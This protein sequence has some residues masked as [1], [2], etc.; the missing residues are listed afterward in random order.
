[1]QGVSPLCLIN[2]TYFRTTVDLHYENIHGIP[3]VLS[4]YSDSSNTSGRLWKFR[5]TRTTSIS[6]ENLK[7]PCV[8]SILYYQN[9]RRFEDAF[10]R[11]KIDSSILSK[12]VYSKTRNSNNI[13]EKF[14]KRS[15]CLI[16]YSG[17]MNIY[18][19][20]NKT[21]FQQARK[22]GLVYINHQNKSNLELHC[23]TADQVIQVH[24]LPTA[25]ASRIVPLIDLCFTQASGFRIRQVGLNLNPKEHWMKLP[26]QWLI[27]FTD[28]MKFLN[29]SLIYS[30]NIIFPT[31]SFGK[32][33]SAWKLETYVMISSYELKIL[34]CYVEKYVN[35][36][37]YISAFD[38]TTWI[39]ILL[40]GLLMSGLLY[41]HIRQ[42]IPSASSFSPLLFFFSTFM[43][44]SYNIPLALS[45]DKVYRIVVSFWLLLSVIFTNTYVSNVISEIEVPFSGERINFTSYFWAKSSRFFPKTVEEFHKIIPFYREYQFNISEYMQ[46]RRMLELYQY[47]KEPKNPIN[48]TFLEDD[49]LY[50]GFA[51]LSNPLELTHANL[52][53]KYLQLPVRYSVVLQF[54]TEIY[55]CNQNKFLHLPYCSYRVGVLMP[56]NRHYPLR[57]SLSI[58]ID[59]F[60]AKT[61]IENE[62]IQCGKSAY[63]ERKGEGEFKYLSANYPQKSF[64]YLKDSIDGLWVGFNL[65]RMT[66][67]E[68]YKVMVRLLESGYLMRM[69]FLQTDR[70]LPRRINATNLIKKHDRTFVMN[71]ESQINTVFILAFAMLLV[72]T[73]AFV[74]ENQLVARISDHWIK[75]KHSIECCGRI[76]LDNLYSFDTRLNS[77]KEFSCVLL[78]KIKAQIAKV[79]V[80]M[81]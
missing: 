79:R 49:N 50:D 72:A 31:V 16:L 75:V 38:K 42:N 61:A 68:T 13:L 11:N 59:N 39:M 69:I 58:P 51:L 12:W 34:T 25:N 56:V 8:L 81:H 6:I 41:L 30:N 44:E 80:N 2:I 57:P 22:V 52:E 27:F 14:Q 23:K 21:Y 66:N 4:S 24:I 77:D 20:Q 35:Y 17:S 26:K 3:V 28:I 64:Y 40:S 74:S 33:E 10:S 5:K 70:D 62:L 67:S 45:T 46:S 76:F 60:Y 37:M 1:L 36:Y 47:R 18:E 32:M 78:L 29:V 63:M 65:E 19:L 53:E 7:S 55:D 48:F 15:P 43:E 71:M 54:F 9:S 73:M